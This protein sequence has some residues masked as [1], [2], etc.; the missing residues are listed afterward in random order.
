MRAFQSVA[1]LVL[2]SALLL[3]AARHVRLAYFVDREATA[4][5]DPF[6]NRP[7]SPMGGLDRDDDMEDEE[8]Q[9]DA[10]AVR[11]AQ[12]SNELNR[13]IRWVGLDDLRRLARAARA[14]RKAL[15]QELDEAWKR[16]VS[17]HPEALMPDPETGFPPGFTATN[18]YQMARNRFSAQWR[19]EDLARGLAYQRDSRLESALR[20]WKRLM[21]EWAEMI[22]YWSAGLGLFLLGGVLYRW[23]PVYGMALAT[24]GAVLMA[25]W[26]TPSFHLMGGAVSEGERLLFG[27]LAMTAV[28]LAA[29]GAAYALAPRWAKKP[30]SAA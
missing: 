6:S 8:D 27:R 28:A 12:A 4:S 3:T 24:P 26:S 18:A 11:L 10:N 1:F 23:L 29:V 16:H 25:W 21:A 7:M 14:E 20:E 9:E 2:V 30:R 5:H 22:F 15:D 17:E 13:E 19:N